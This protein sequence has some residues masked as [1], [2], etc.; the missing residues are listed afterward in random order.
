MDAAW[1]ASV[2]QWEVA[3]GGVLLRRGASALASASRDAFA[4]LQT[5][6]A[7]DAHAASLRAQLST[8]PSDSTSVRPF[9]AV[10]C[11]DGDSDDNVDDGSSVQA[12]LI[13]RNVRDAKPSEQMGAGKHAAPDGS[14]RLVAPGLIAEDECSL[15]VGGGLVMMA[16]AFSRCGQ[17]TLGV[18]PALSARLLHVAPQQAE[19]GEQAEGGKCALGGTVPLLYVA[20]E[21]ARRRV[22]ETF[23]VPLPSVRMSDATLTRLLPYGDSG[24]AEAPP[25]DY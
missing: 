21:R 7:L 6:A 13:A 14:A 20:V 5:A 2:E 18:S 8:A 17:T 19:G 4:T 15:L 22:A 10:A 11:A 9:A 25:P 12:S 24:A 16:G 1:R 23:G 3:G